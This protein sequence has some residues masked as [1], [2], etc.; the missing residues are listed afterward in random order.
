MELRT[1]TPA[2]AN[3]VRHSFLQA[4]GLRFHLALAGE[5][6]A[7]APLLLMLHGFPECWY[8][9]R[10]QLA[11][12]GDRFFCAAP[13]LRGYGQ[14]DK[15]RTG[16]DLDTLAD[17]VA[18]LVR[19]LGRERAVV[20]GHDWGGALAWHFARRHPGL[21]EGLVVLNCPPPDIMLGHFLKNPT[22][23]RRSW[24]M[25]FFN[26]PWLPERRLSRDGCRIVPAIF[27]AGAAR[28]EAFSKEDLALF[29]REMAR[30]G[31]VRGALSWY[32]Q[33]FRRMLGPTAIARRL[34]RR[35]RRPRPITAPGLILWGR[36][37]PFLGQELLDGVTGRFG[38]PLT[39][40]LLDGCG[41]WTQQEAVGAVH[42][43]LE[44]FLSRLRTEDADA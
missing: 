17:D 40:R 19:A 43:E 23:L 10:H 12:F 39:V 33:A 42:E 20:I 35:R 25:F 24:Y 13:D 16:Y 44:R 27:K 38:G 26:L 32:R 15:P 34:V 7:D 31:A 5:G 3:G 22:Q 1:D 21:L 11:A 18:A 9:W 14:T 8:S 29:R 36:D 6:N 37:D 2:A 4:N 30:P 28:R 41:H